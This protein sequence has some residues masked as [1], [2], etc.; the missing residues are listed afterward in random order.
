MTDALRALELPHP[1]LRMKKKKGKKNV[2]FPF[3]FVDTQTWAKK[4]HGK[5]AIA[6]DEKK[7]PCRLATTMSS[8][9]LTGETF[10][11]PQPRDVVL[12]KTLVKNPFLLVILHGRVDLMLHEEKWG[13]GGGRAAFNKYPIHQPAEFLVCLL[14]TGRESI[15]L[16]NFQS[17][18]CRRIVFFSSFSLL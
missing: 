17:E 2:E 9:Y 4:L 10:F 11:T 12:R 15:A 5:C 16:L 3:T 7:S 6:G 8:G 18:S 13:G 14:A 1:R